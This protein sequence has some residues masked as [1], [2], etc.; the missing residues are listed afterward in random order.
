MHNIYIIPQDMQLH[1]EF[2]IM[3][4]NITAIIIILFICTM[5]TYIYKMAYTYKL[6][7]SLTTT[8]VSD[9]VY[10]HYQLILL[11][12]SLIMIVTS[13]LNQQPT[14]LQ[15]LVASMYLWHSLCTWPLRVALAAFLAAVQSAWLHPFA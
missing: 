14:F 9:I 13:T 12:I 1:N 8:D 4:G 3:H 15:G 10:A 5:H 11:S 2:A 6:R 7:L